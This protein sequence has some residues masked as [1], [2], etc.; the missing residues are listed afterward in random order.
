M[1]RVDFWVFQWYQEEEEEE[2]KNYR[3]MVSGRARSLQ[4]T[5]ADDINESYP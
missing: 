5:L 1:S 4:P 2:K 3:E